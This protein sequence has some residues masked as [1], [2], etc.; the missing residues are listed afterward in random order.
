MFAQAQFVYR[1]PTP[2]FRVRCKASA[3]IHR[4]SDENSK[5]INQVHTNNTLHVLAFERNG[6]EGIYSVVER[7]ETGEEINQIIAFQTF[8]EAFRYKIL[9]EAD[10]ELKPHVEFVS[11]YELNHTCTIGK[12]ACRVVNIGSLLIPPTKTRQVTDW[13]VDMD[14]YL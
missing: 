2:R 1:V 8:D 12:Y 9:L 4:L 6:Q 10:T 3:S 14:K 11:Q 13:E 5:D 7:T